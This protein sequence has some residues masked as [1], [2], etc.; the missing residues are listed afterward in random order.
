M[1]IVSPQHILSISRRNYNFFAEKNEF[2]L[3]S[4]S[5]EIKK[6]DNFYAPPGIVRETKNEVR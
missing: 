5:R 6:R 3:F 2:L 1:E 4:F